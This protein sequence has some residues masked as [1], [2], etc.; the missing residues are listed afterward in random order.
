MYVQGKQAKRNVKDNLAIEHV[1]GIR[2]KRLENTKS[3]KNPAYEKFRAGTFVLLRKR[4]VQPRHMVKANPVYHSQP[5]RILRRT[6]TNAV[7]VPF[8]LGY[9]GIQI[10]GGYPKEPLYTPAFEQFKTN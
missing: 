2:T 8:G 6:E 10:R 5:F 9:L 1:K 3:P 4:A 7:I